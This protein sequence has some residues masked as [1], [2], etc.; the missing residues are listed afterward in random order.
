MSLR[1]YQE[2]CLS[3]I[4]SALTKKARALIVMATGAGKSR[5]IASLHR[6][7]PGPTKIIYLVHKIPLVRQLHAELTAENLSCGIVCGSIGRYEIDR[8]YVVATYQTLIGMLDMMPRF[9]VAVIDEC[10]R[11]S[12]AHKKIVHSMT[13]RRQDFK[14]IGCTATPF[15]GLGFIYNRH[16]F[17]KDNAS[18][19]KYALEWPAPCFTK[20][21]VTLTNEGHLVPAKMKG[22][23]RALTTNIRGMRTY[24]GDYLVSALEDEATVEKTEDQVRE[25]LRLLRGRKKVIWACISITHAQL[26]Q[27]VLE[28]QGENAAICTSDDDFSERELQLGNFTLGPARNLVFVS[29]VSEGFDF[30]PIDA[31]V[32]LRATRSPALYIQTV[33]RG[34]RPYEGK[35]DC[36]IIDYGRIVETLGPIDNPV[37]GWIDVGKNNVQPATLINRGERVICCK[38]CLTIYVVSVGEFKCC[39]DCGVDQEKARLNTRAGKLLASASHSGELYSKELKM[40]TDGVVWFKITDFTFT[41]RDEKLI[42]TFKLDGFKDFEYTLDVPDVHGLPS[43]YD[44]GRIRSAKKFLQQWFGLA[45]GSLYRMIGDLANPPRVPR[46]VGLSSDTHEL[47]SFSS[48]ISE[49]A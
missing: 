23:S 48:G 46:L 36:L 15:D 39:P 44:M 31:V 34:L 25:A 28:D 17:T 6:I 24:M 30:P 35:K 29:I 11:S 45:D 47:R 42:L 10:H 2:E 4:K 12:E 7:F 38:G 26:V 1:P 13:V 32:L 16:H 20:G 8:Q 9:D 33:G 5:V 19:L 37:V 40:I 3:A 27:A 14:L 41:G 21:I 22:G 18:R 49:L 43:K